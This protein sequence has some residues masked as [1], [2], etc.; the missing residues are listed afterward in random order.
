MTTFRRPAPSPLPSGGLAAV[1][2]AGRRRR[3]VVAATSG[4]AVTAGGLVL[5]ALLVASPGTDT[6][7]PAATSPSPTATSP[8]PTATPRYPGP[9]VNLVGG[10]GSGPGTPHP[11]TPLPP[12]GGWAFEGRV[13][14]GPVR[15]LRLRAC[16][17]GAPGDSTLVERELPGGANARPDFSVVDA[18]GHEV[19][20]MQR[21]RRM[22]APEPDRTHYTAIDGRCLYWEVEWNGRT[23]EGTKVPP[24]RYTVRMYLTTT[25]RSV[26][27]LVEMPL[28]V[29]P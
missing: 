3:R 29:A 26:P 4:G 20:A 23:F 18:T 5:A 6:L 25:D 1:V 28:V 27:P 10:S 19:W 8:S 16:A 12:D 22:W 21:V 9:E 17:V 7:R 14:R 2:R 11:T 24:G 15:D 13:G